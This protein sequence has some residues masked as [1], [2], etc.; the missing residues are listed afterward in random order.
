[1]TDTG[2]FLSVKNQNVF[3]DATYMPPL[4]PELAQGA[5][6]TPLVSREYA[7]RKGPIA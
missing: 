6:V 1:L 7:R 4:P 5:T 2:L 3:L